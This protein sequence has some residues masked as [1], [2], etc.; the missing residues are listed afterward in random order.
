MVSST[1]APTESGTRLRPQPGP[2]HPRHR[3]HQGNRARLVVLLAVTAVVVLRL[4]FLGA[5]LAADEAGDLYV[6]G[7]WAL[8]SPGRSLYGDFWVDRPPLLV[9]LFGLADRLGGAVPLRLVGLLACAVTVLA[10]VDTVDRLTRA[11]A[12]PAPTPTSGRARLASWSPG[13]PAAWAA[14]ATAALLVTPRT[15]ALTVNGEVLAAP[16]LAVA[17]AATVRAV[18]GPGGPARPALLAGACAVAAVLVKQNLV[19]AAVWGGLLTLAS[20]PTVGARRAARVLGL[21]AA[22]GLATLVVVAGWTVLHGTSLVGVW[23]AMYPFR[24]ASRHYLLAHPAAYNAV[25]LHQLVR[26]AASSGTVLLAVLLLGLVVAGT[27]D[28]VRD[29][30]HAHR[31]AYAAGL[32]TAGTLV[33]GVV[34]ID[35]GGFFWLHYLVQLVVPLG[36]AAGLVAHRWRRIGAAVALA[37][38]ISALVALGATNRTP[39]LGHA[40]SVGSAVGRVAAHGDTIVT[41]FGGADVTRASGLGSPYPELWFLPTVVRDPRLDLMVRTLDG[42]RA[43]TWFVDLGST[44]PHLTPGAPR[45]RRALRQHYRRVADL[46]GSGV[47][48]HDGVVRATPVITG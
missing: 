40:A 13:W 16:F 8:L 22:G 39:H 1:A 25:R 31:S 24:V 28:V 46:G 44:R 5:D 45:L 18:R 30:S 35:L 42:A 4:P 20:I 48:L 23:E 36:L 12:G 32:A 9:T 17:C 27:L 33:W 29:R 11:P 10:A 47:W 6:G 21:A 14:V 34:S 26:A 15:D 41:V 43:P 38:A 3:G 19:D 2:Q 37:V 7:R